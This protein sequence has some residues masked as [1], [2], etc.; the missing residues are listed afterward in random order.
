M[1]TQ[2]ILKVGQ[3]I[4]CTLYGGRDGYVTR[5]TGEQRPDT[6]KTLLGG[7][8]VA[9]GN[10]EIHIVFPNHFSSVPESLVRNSVQWRIYDEFVSDA[11]LK[12]T[13]ANTQAFIDAKYKAEELE[14]LKKQ[15]EET[16]QLTAHEYNHLKPVEKWFSAAETAVNIRAELKKQYP[17]VKFGVR[18]SSHSCI[19]VEWVDGP[20]PDKVSNALENFKGTAGMNMDDSVNYKSHAWIFGTV[21]YLFCQQSH[22]DGVLQSAI[23]KINTRFNNNATVEQYRRGFLPILCQGADCDSYSRELRKVLAG[24][25]D[26]ELEDKHYYRSQ[27]VRELLNADF[28]F[29][30]GYKKQGSEL[31]VK[32]HYGN[33]Y[34]GPGFGINNVDQHEIAD[35]FD[36]PVIDI[37]RKINDAY[38]LQAEKL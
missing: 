33:W 1:N 18:K 31:R 32:Y 25:V 30:N 34:I 38:D 7:I 26:Y 21:D 12:M 2:S 28:C 10:A 24:E 37:A 13:I 3:K 19:N 5:I 36:I 9:G 14:G 17:G 8:G 16:R 35:N 6:C 11:V 29:I 23:D 4:H 20:A 22:S 27:A 15:S